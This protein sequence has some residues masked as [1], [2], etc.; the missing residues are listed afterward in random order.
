[1]FVFANYQ[2]ICPCQI[3]KYM[4]VSNIKIYGRV[5]YQ[6]VCPSQISKCLTI[7]YRNICLF[8]I[9]NVWL[10]QKSKC[11]TMSEHGK[12]LFLFSF[13]HVVF[14]NLLNTQ[15]AIKIKTSKTIKIILLLCQAV[16]KKTRT[17][18]KTHKTTIKTIKK[19]YIDELIIKLYKSKELNRN[20]FSSMYVQLWKLLKI[21]DL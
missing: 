6:N 3:S 19:I 8:Q 14:D 21:K 16:L 5:K 18:Q 15:C 7:N 1:M 12:N 11:L 20:I 13:D 9:S 2:N 17:T 10:C 4:S